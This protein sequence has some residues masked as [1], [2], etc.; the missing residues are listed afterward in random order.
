[1]HGL[2]AT[3]AIWSNGNT[4]KLR[5]NRGGV[6]STKTCNISETVQDR[7]KDAYAFR[8][9]PKSMTLD[10]LERQKR[11]L[12]ETKSFYGAHRKKIA[13]INEWKNIHDVNCCKTCNV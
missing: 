7:T 10:D 3:W 2:T 6:M 4:P 5:W 11:T 9:V 8:L 13:L 1:M 12:A